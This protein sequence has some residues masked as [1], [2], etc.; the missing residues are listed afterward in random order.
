MSYHGTETCHFGFEVRNEV[1]GPETKFLSHGNIKGC[2]RYIFA[3]L[4]CMSKREHL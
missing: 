2:V 1:K 4:F 3:C